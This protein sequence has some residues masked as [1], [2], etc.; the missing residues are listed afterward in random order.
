MNVDNELTLLDEVT[1]EDLAGEHQ[2]WTGL[3]IRE[4]VETVAAGTGV[5]VVPMSVARLH[6]RKDVTHRTVTDLPST[7]V[8]LTWLVENDDPRVQTFIGIVR[9]RSERSSARRRPCRRPSTRVQ[10][11]F[12]TSP[13]QLVASGRPLGEP[14]GR[15]H[16]DQARSRS[17][18]S[19]D[20]APAS[21]C[22]LTGRCSSARSPERGVAGQT[23]RVGSTRSLAVRPLSQGVRVEGDSARSRS[24]DPPRA[25]CIWLASGHDGLE[26][27]LEGLRRDVLAAGGPDQ[28]LL[29]SVTRRRPAIVEPPTS[30]EASQP[31]RSSTSRRLGQVVVAAHHARAR[32]AGSRR[33]P[34]TAPPCRRAAGRRRPITGSP[35][36]LT[37][38]APASMRSAGALGG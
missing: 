11:R 3:T 31:R 4:S 14:G 37:M 28:V 21:A 23:V 34:A 1:T 8:G 19:P 2:D 5:L 22:R 18:A 35:E 36:P 26:R 20:A 16:A 13:H 10:Q 7:T 33:R 38:S 24:C 17:S 9:G 6:H 25:R 12:G 30:P 27:D 32:A 29:P 15:L